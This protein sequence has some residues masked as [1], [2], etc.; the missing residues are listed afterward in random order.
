MFPYLAFFCALIKCVQNGFS[1]S[2]AIVAEWGEVIFVVSIVVY[3]LVDISDA[4][5]Y[6]EVNIIFMGHIVGAECVLPHAF[7]WQYCLSY[8]V[9]LHF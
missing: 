9:P 6:F 3:F 5:Y 1:L 8:A 4:M 2:F 7:P